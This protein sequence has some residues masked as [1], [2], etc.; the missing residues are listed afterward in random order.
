MFFTKQADQNSSTL[1]V[2]AKIEELI[3]LLAGGKSRNKVNSSLL[4]NRVDTLTKKIS[5]NNERVEILN[6]R[7][8]AERELLLN[9]F[10]QMER[11]IG[12]LQ[13]NLSALRSLTVL[14]PLGTKSSTGLFG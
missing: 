2:S 3:D 9:Q 4:T 14:S 13:N 11:I 12:Q 7:L 6:R 10:Y 5:S 8:E 1:G